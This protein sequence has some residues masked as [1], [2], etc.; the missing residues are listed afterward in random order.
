MGIRLI[1]ISPEDDQRWDEFVF[2]HPMGSIYHHSAWGNVLK[3]TFDHKFFY[4]ALEDIETDKLKGIVPFMLVK[5]WL[6]GQRLVSLPFT[7][8]CNPLI[9][10]EHLKNVISFVFE[11][12]LEIDYLELKF[13]KNDEEYVL[14]GFEELSTY[15][16]HILTLD[17]P[18]EQLFRSFHNTSV[19]QRIKRADKNKLKLRMAGK[20][21]DL[22]KFYSLQTKIRKVY[23]LPPQPYTFFKNMW[24]ILKPKNL[25]FVP[26]IEYNGRVIAGAMVL[27]FKDTFYFE[28]SA[29]DQNFL[30]LGP[31]HKLIWEVIKIAHKEGARY[32]DFGRSSLSH[33]SLIEFKDRWGAKRHKLIYYYY[34]KANRIDT[35]NGS[36]RKYL[37]LINSHFPL[38]FL[39]LEGKLIYPHLS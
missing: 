27:K 39:R 5:S 35:E 23:G 25:L 34:P 22:E 16:T 20:E 8:Y 29:S 24:E 6:T 30:K 38:S 17:I 33:R 2:R 32:F 31:N 18:L 10:K 21:E 3:S 37:A 13:I 12:N 9:P 1:I 14:E 11:F 7:T 4:V 15:V 28:Y 36:R 19:R 26:L